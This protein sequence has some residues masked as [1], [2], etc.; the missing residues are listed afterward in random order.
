MARV[1][2]AI[3]FDERLKK[4]IDVIMK[5]IHPLLAEGRFTSPANLHLT[6]K[7]IGEVEEERAA[8]LAARINDLKIAPFTLKASGLGT[9]KTREGRTLYLA[10]EPSEELLSL[11]ARVLEILRELGVSPKDEK[12]FV[13]HVTIARKAKLDLA[14]LAPFEA[15]AQSIEQDVVAATLFETEFV[16]GGLIYHKR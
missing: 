5:G 10:F 1:F 6:L 9:F 8:A 2:V 4:Q 3:A 15:A 12:P 11:H 14:S 16:E 13:P 7:F